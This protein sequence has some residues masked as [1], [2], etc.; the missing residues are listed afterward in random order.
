MG[1]S[2]FHIQSI[3]RKHQVVWWASEVGGGPMGLS[4]LPVESIS[5]Q[6]M[7]ELG[8]LLGYLAGIWGLLV[9]VG[10]AS[11]QVQIGSGTPFP[12]S[13]HQPHFIK[14]AVESKSTWW[15]CSEHRASDPDSQSLVHFVSIIQ[16]HPPKLWNKCLSA[17]NR[18]LQFIIIVETLSLHCSS[19]WFQQQ[20]QCQLKSHCWLSARVVLH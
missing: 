15:L 5:R 20:A 3:R 13:S 9:G 16:G 8:W 1:T 11:P 18:H 2:E 4:L 12:T 17:L 10:K 19:T 7:S 14:G 6:I